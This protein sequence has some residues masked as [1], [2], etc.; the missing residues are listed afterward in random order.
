MRGL[1]GIA[2][3]PGHAGIQVVDTPPEHDKRMVAAYGS[4]CGDPSHVSLY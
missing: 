1:C 2:A 3:R 4:A